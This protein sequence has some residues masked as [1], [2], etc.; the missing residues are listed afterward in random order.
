MNA[1]PNNK[2]PVLGRLQALEA[3][4]DLCTGI[5]MIFLLGP[6]FY[7]VTYAYGEGSARELL[8]MV[9][10]NFWLL[11]RD[12]SL[13]TVTPWLILGIA[14]ILGIISRAIFTIYNIFPIKYLEKKVIAWTSFQL[15]KRWHGLSGGWTVQRIVKEFIEKTPFHRVGE[16]D[17]AQFRAKLD[18]PTSNIKGLKPLWDHEFFLYFRSQHFYGMFLSFFLI[19]IIYGIGVT[20]VKGLVF[21]EFG[22]WLGVLFLLF[23]LVILLFQEV[24][25]HGVAFFQINDLAWEQFHSTCQRKRNGS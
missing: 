14:F 8:I 6:L 1:K 12:L 2:V 7:G 11:F 20:A 22:L 3:I 5:L 9:F 21:P 25:I 19:Y 15:V 16:S 23:I 18:D 24:I 17:F 4:V 13:A 10:P